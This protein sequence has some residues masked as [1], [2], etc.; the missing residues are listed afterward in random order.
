MNRDGVRAS[1][2][3]VAREAG[4]T[5][6]VVSRVLNA[7]PTLQIRSATRDRVLAAAR[8]LDYVPSHAARAL[9]HSQ[10]NAIGLA[11]HD[12]ANPVYSEIIVGAQRAAAEAGYVLLLAD[13]DSIAHGDERFRRAVHG[14]AID[15]LLLQ[16]AGTGA[17]RRVVQTASARIPTVLLND[18]SVGLASVGLDDRGG[19]RLATQYLL[20]LGHTEIAHLR[21]GGTGRSGARVRGWRDTLAHAGLA[22]RQEWVVDGGHTVDMG[23]AG[24]R[25]LLAVP[26]LP[27]AVVV[28]N[29]LA[30]IGAMTAIRD[31]GLRVPG[32]LSVVALHDIVYAAH[33]APA[34]TTVTM[35]LRELGSMAVILLLEELAGGAPRHVVLKEPAPRLIT[36]DSTAPPNGY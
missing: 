36:R 26:Q 27:T 31:A 1:I 22:A 23:Y 18:R 21:V 2:S 11:V 19:T 28:G 15:G 8:E 10:S 24:M 34:L 3:D 4:V 17:D 12:I 20:D 13:V 33:L 32:D 9:R 14:G 35:P 7:D 29:V 6:G 25:E 5:S 30:A 16:R